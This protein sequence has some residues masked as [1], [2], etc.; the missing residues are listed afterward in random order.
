MTRMLGILWYSFE[1][2]I[3]KF[4]IRCSGGNPASSTAPFTPRR[5]T[6]SLRLMGWHQNCHSC[7]DV[8]IFD[9]C[10]RVVGSFGVKPDARG[11]RPG[12]PCRY[13]KPATGWGE[14]A[15]LQPPGTHRTR[16]LWS[17]MECNGSSRG[18]SHI[19]TGELAN[20]R[21]AYNFMY[22]SIYLSIYIYIHIMRVVFG[23]PITQQPPKDQ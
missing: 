18:L 16:K 13:L 1:L 8:M 10:S 5:S 3:Q 22:L 23:K 7:G 21:Q 2:T 11:K 6:G 12:R 9:G 15:A 4:F 19:E 17:A 14:S 20:D